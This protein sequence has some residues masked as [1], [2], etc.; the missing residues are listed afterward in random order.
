MTTVDEED[1][2][3]AIVIG[4]GL[5]GLSAAYRLAQA[6]R[7]VLVVERGA[8]CGAKTFTGG[9]L[10]TYSL[11]ELLGERWREAPLQREI[12]RE[13]IS[14]LT[15]T[16]AMNVDTTFAD[17]AGRSYSVLSTPLVAWLAEQCEQAGAEIIPGATVT[18]L[19]IRDGVVRG[20]RMGDEELTSALVIDAE[21]INPLVFERAGLVRRLAREDVAVGVKYLF[22]LTE[23]EVDRRF[24]TSDRRG[25]AMLGMGAVTKGLFGG[26]FL[27]TNI[28]SVSL[29]LVVDSDSWREHGHSLV[30]TAEDLRQHPAVGRY[31]A[32]GELV[33]YGAHLVY[34]GNVD[35]LP[36]LFGDG[37]LIAG[38]AAGFCI[39][40]GFTIR[41]MDY[42]IASGIA[43]GETAAAALAAG[44]VSATRLSAYKARLEGGVLADMAKVRGAHHWMAHTPDLFSTYPALA[45]G[46]MRDMFTVDGGP[47]VPVRSTLTG[48]VKKV[49][50]KLSTALNLVK[51]V[52]SL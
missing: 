1:A 7:S 52:R 47:L 27:Y 6:G 15:D 36:Q 17:P 9:R 18:G 41:G 49:P 42:A 31:V 29:G 40:R 8:S 34:E 38:D 35:T 16:E 5:A 43:A 33:E 3:E 20:V 4:G 14:M 48:T 45:V 25:T 12:D 32:G 11:R 30:Q 10:Y 37:W 13:V 50:K 21:G 44:D 2:F 39:N 46:L 51:G 24:T 26:L 23:E 28:D 19:V 22:K